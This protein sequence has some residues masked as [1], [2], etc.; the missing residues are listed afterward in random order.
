MGKPL[1]FP[2]NDTVFL[3]LGGLFLQ[4]R[5]VIATSRAGPGVESNL[6][7]GSSASSRAYL[8]PFGG[9]EDYF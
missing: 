9:A 3:S 2:R 7:R 4:T 6:N 8:D 1:Y 5:K